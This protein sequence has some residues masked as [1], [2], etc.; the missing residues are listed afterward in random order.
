MN[1]H[2]QSRWINLDL[3][4]TEI[5]RLDLPATITPSF[6][7]RCLRFARQR[8]SPLHA[9]VRRLP[10]VS[11]RDSIYRTIMVKSY[12]SPP[13]PPDWIPAAGAC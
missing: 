8:R 10:P 6:P 7:G 1:S 4:L 13:A 2:L 11:P 9:L 3:G 5:S 12:H